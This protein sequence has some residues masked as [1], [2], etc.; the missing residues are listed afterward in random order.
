[1]GLLTAALVVADEKVR[2]ELRG[3]LS[4]LSVRLVMEQP[5]AAQWS[6]FMGR[7]RRLTP[8]LLLIDAPQFQ[9]PFV[10]AAHEIKSLSPGP[11]V[12]AVIAEADAEAALK[13]IRAGANECVMPPFDSSL[14]EA[15]ERVCRRRTASA[16]EQPPAGK[17]IGFLS[18]KGGC[19]ATTIACHVAMGL[20]QA[21]AHDV[22]LADFDLDV[23]M[24]GYLMKAQTPYSLLDAVKR[25]NSPDFRP[26]GELVWK[27]QSRLEVLPAPA[28]PPCKEPLE[29]SQF[30][31]ALKFMQSQYGWVV[32][33]LGRGFNFLSRAL[34]E[35]LDRLFLVSTPEVPALYQAKQ[36]VQ[37]LV[38][39]GYDLHRLA[40]ILN[41]APKHREF[42]S[43]ELRDLLGVRVSWELAELPEL[44]Q[45]FGQGRLV[46]AESPSGRQL[47]ALAM[48]IAGVSPVKIQS[49]YSIFG[50]KRL[51]PEWFGA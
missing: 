35:E 1:V 40:L 45:A 42:T 32:A 50:L 51:L 46:A 3:A 4:S 9:D 20:R 43:K 36:M 18:V 30:R 11:A 6:A 10:A 28:K 34:V 37:S 15:L 24:V 38:G 31:E 41:R 19:G 25:H 44:E 47:A 29:V 7:L 33:D 12:L 21:T 49:Q 17:A 23:G 13:A 16:R 48:K 22:L 5:A 14:R 27:A 39:G 26:W 2:E 8:D